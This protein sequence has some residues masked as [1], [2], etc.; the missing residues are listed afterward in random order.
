MARYF[1][2]IAS[3]I[4]WRETIPPAT[5]FVARPLTRGEQLEITDLRI[6]F[7]VERSLAKTPNQADLWISN[8]AESTRADLEVKPL[9]VQLNAGFDGEARLLFDGDLRF[10]MSEQDGPTWTTLMQLGDGDRA[11]ANARVNRSY[12]DGT[13]YRTVLTDVAHSMGVELPKRLATDPALDA[14][15]LTGA[16]VAGYSRDVLSEVLPF[17]YH[18]SFQNGNLEILRDDQVSST[19]AILIDKDHGLIGSP[20]F[21]SPPRSGKPPHVTVKCQ[22]NPELVPG[23]LVELVSRAKSGFFRAEKVRHLGDTHGNEWRTE[24]EI[25]PM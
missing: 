9:A 23:C 4:A 14:Q 11:Y 24:V 6:R 17:G 12:K 16:S 8:L 1:Q 2:K 20:K 25:K 5:S 10:G 22:I 15:F 19:T 7:K 3:V 13:T 21:G 18:W